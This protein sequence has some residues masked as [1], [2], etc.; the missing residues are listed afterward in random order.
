MSNT[1]TDYLVER[2]MFVRR[3]SFWRAVAFGV[4]ILAI[5]ALGYRFSGAGAGSHLTPH[6]AR[7]TIEGL[8]VGDKATIKLLEDVGK[9]RA[10]AVVLAID[11][12]GGT[13]AGSERLYDEIRRLAARKPVAAVVGNVAAS[14][15]YIAAM[16]ADEIVA[17]GNSL[18]G[19]IGVLFQ[20]PNVSNLLES[21]GVK[22][23]EIKSSPLKAAPNPMTPTTEEAKQAIDKLVKDS[24][25]WFKGL[26]QERRKLDDAQL[27]VVSDGRVFTGRQGL[28]LKLVDRIGGEREA[29]AWLESE[30][31]VAR[32]LPVR[33][34]KKKRTIETLGILGLARFG[35]ESIGLDGAS[36]LLARA[37]ALIETRKIDGLMS[38]WQV[39]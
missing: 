35:L 30:K 6:I 20:V 8:I 26:V 19:S 28:A 31:G 15:A 27:A 36:G 37:D 4:A 12:P 5:L 21:I 33:D 32:G 38:I 2:R 1:P 24:Y 10:S 22:Y 18:V 11:S 14:G 39:H 23:E 25:A 3:L 29:V 17:H 7:V 34:W 16:G 13:T 9:S